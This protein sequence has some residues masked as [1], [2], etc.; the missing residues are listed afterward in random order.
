ML[1]KYLQLRASQV[2]VRIEII[3][4][5]HSSFERQAEVRKCGKINTFHEGTGIKLGNWRSTASYSMTKGTNN[6]VAISR[7]AR[8]VCMQLN[9]H[10]LSAWEND[11]I[12]A[13]YG[14]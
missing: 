8:E 3:S 7:H 10:V 12:E 6:L 11:F 1:E 5:S 4:T 13:G 2:T 9:R 14:S